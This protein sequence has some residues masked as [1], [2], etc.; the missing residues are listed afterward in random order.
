VVWC[1]V[2]QNRLLVTQS[3]FYSRTVWAVLYTSFGLFVLLL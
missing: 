1:G 3:G 2:A